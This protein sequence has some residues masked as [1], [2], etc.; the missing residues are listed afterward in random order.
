MGKKTVTKNYIYNVIY[1]IIA[2]ISP[3]I[4]TPYLSRILGADGIG[5]YSYTYSITSFLMVFAALGFGYYGQREI[6]KVQDDREKQTC[7]FW[8]IFLL[9]L[10]SVSVC[11]LVMALLPKISLFSY[12]QNLLYIWI[13]QI[14]AVAFD[15]T[16]LFY[17]NEN[18]G[19]VV[20][21][22]IILKAISIALIFI[23]V[24]QR[25]QVWI[26]VLCVAGSSFLGNISLWPA[27]P[28]LINKPTFS[29]LHFKR[30]IIPM[31]RLFI[32]AIASSVYS[33]IDKF[34]I[35][36]LVPGT[37]I[38]ETTQIVDG[39]QVIVKVEKNISDLENGYYEQAVKLINLCTTIVI[40]LGTVITPRNTKL[41]A[42]KN[43]DGFKKNLNVGIK[44]TFFVGVP[45]A[46]GLAAISR[47][48]IPWFFGDEYSACEQLIYIMCP[49]I[50]LLGLNNLFGL[51]ILVAQSKDSKY[52]L[53]IL[54]SAVLNLALDFILIPLLY[55]SGAAVGSV[56]AEFVGVFVMWL[57][58][59]KD[60]GLSEILKQSWK[61]LLSGAVMF[62]VVYTTDCFISSSVLN[63]LLLILLGA[64]VYFILLFIMNEEFTKSLF[65]KA[66]SYFQSL[67]KRKV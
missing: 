27:V 3:L 58:C 35:G 29:Q 28:K 67:F 13:I 46:F 15:I 63:T 40:S 31:L 60:V 30:H 56:I 44:Y 49:L 23:F 66:V 20:L 17:G 41:F 62:G 37:Y 55:S 57:F 61:F 1:Q 12:Y 53:G 50:L 32:P 7:L 52:T 47:N 11:C 18:F 51:Q 26:Y 64:F 24:K 65:K 59:R 39:A 48:L 54:I 21:R 22:N 34:L 45:L 36:V 2:I 14:A 16:F 25:E 5:Q 6:A 4:T 19:G 38:Q 10:I 9:R 33:T 43:I 8:E 42:D